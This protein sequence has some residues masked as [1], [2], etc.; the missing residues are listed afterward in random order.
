[1]EVRTRRPHLVQLLPLALLPATAWAQGNPVGPEFRVNTYT[2]SAQFVPF[3]SADPSG[4]FVVAWTSANQDGDQNGVFAQRYAASGAA[5][6]TEFRVNT[7]TAGYQAEPAVAADASGN[8]VVVWASQIQD[9]SGFGIFGQRYGSSGAPVG[10]EFRVN[11]FTT[12]DQG[13][14]LSVASD[15]SGNFVV[16]W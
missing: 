12:N 14:Y 7:F 2:T 13:R 15:P 9:G 8:F 10:P 4:N 16:A 3:V 5:L 1:M 11:T 6:G